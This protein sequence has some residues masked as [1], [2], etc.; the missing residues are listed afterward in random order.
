MGFS[1]YLQSIDTPIEY[2]VFSTL[3]FA[4]LVGLDLYQNGGKVIKSFFY[5]VT[6]IINEQQGYFHKNEEFISYINIM[7]PTSNLQ[8]IPCSNPI[9]ANYLSVGKIQT[10]KL[11]Q[12]V[13]LREDAP[14]KAVTEC[15]NYFNN[16]SEN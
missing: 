13:I 12:K 11:C 4:L 15:K 5:S 6:K 7:Y 14:D 10:K 2:L 9:P 3:M 8:L 1:R 16:N